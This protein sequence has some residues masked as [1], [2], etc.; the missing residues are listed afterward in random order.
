MRTTH[1][2]YVDIGIGVYLTYH[3]AMQNPDGFTLLEL[4][5]AVALI[6]ILTGAALLGYQRTLA[7]ARLNAAARQVVMDLKLTRARA[8]LDGATHRVRFTVP[9]RSYQH[10]RQRPDGGYEAAGPPTDLPADVDVVGCTGAGSGISFRPRG[11][12]GAFGTVALRNRDG[13]ERDVVVDIAG[14]LR[15]Q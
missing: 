4:L 13:A 9:G 15:V 1:D 10:E 14:R 6:A 11:L 8:L 3:R 7:G 5:I 2:C 12:A